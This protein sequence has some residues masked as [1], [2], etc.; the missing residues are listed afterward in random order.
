MF[1]KNGS[2]D[3]QSLN[4]N[5]FIL[6]GLVGEGS[7]GK[8]FKVKEKTTDKIY[9][10]K[11]SIEKITNEHREILTNLLREI[12]ILA[13]LNHP[14]ILNFKGYSPMNFKKKPKPVIITEY[15]SNGTLDDLI[16]LERDSKSE[17]DSTRKLII[18]YGIASAM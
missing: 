13:K 11:I 1:D 6:Q 5:D 4:L 8:V 14:C 2:E 7:F 3:G 9:A 16:Q 17:F 15:A 12:N 10:A 18:I